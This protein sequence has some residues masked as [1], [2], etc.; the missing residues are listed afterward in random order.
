MRYYYYFFFLSIA[1][2]IQGNNHSNDVL[3]RKTIYDE[4]TTNLSEQLTSNWPGNVSNRFSSSINSS[5]A[6]LARDYRFPPMEFEC[7]KFQSQRVSRRETTIDPLS[8][9]LFLE[10]AFFIRD[11]PRRNGVRKAWN[12]N[13]AVY[14]AARFSK[15]ISR[16]TSDSLGI[17]VGKG[18]KP[19]ARECNQRASGFNSTNLCNAPSKYPPLFCHSNSS[20]F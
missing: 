10:L 20:S 4:L 5:R 14:L 6:R 7:Q 16:Y 13:A 11:L 19:S 1:L 9:S 3:E 2:K 18:S 12:F 15:N 17:Y 8:F